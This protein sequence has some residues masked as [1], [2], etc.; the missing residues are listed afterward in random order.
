MQLPEFLEGSMLGPV[1]PLPLPGRAGVWPWTRLLN[2][3][4][5]AIGVMWSAQALAMGPQIM[6]FILP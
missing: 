1:C 4:Q 3:Q 5:M 6:G 2:W